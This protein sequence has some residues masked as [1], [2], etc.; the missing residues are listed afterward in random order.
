MKSKTFLGLASA[1]IFG[2]ALFLGLAVVV[3]LYF[4]SLRGAPEEEASLAT[5]NDESTADEF[6]VLYDSANQ[7]ITRVKLNDGS[8]QTFELGL[9]ENVYVWQRALSHDGR[10]L[11]FCTVDQRVEGT[12]SI[13]LIVRDIVASQNIYEQD[14]GNIPGCNPSAFSPDKQR[15]AVGFVYNSPIEGQMNYPDEPDWAL[16]VLDVNSG[17]IVQEIN[18]DSSNAPAF[19]SMTGYWFEEGISPMA[20]V[21]YFGADHIYFLAYPFVG[22]DGPPAV[23]A[24]RWDFASNSLS[25]IEGLGNNGASFLPQTGEIVYPYH[26]PAFPAAQPM[27]PMALANEIVISDSEGTRTIYR[28]T[29]NVIA[30][31]LFV[32]GG[33]QLA[34]F[35]VPHYVPENEAT[36]PT[37]RHILLNR[38]GT[39]E[40][41]NSASQNYA[42]IFATSDGFGILKVEQRD[43]G[44]GNW[45]N[46]HQIF[47]YENEQLNRIWELDAAM[48]PRG[49]VWMELTWASPQNIAPNLEPF[50]AIN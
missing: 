23:P 36:A 16:R 38:D 40:N 28:D 14:F 17:N 24:F 46:F 41:L 9:A 19:G 29:E 32:N 34:V 35:L 26:N 33:R 42:Q 30:S 37:N 49:A 15:L 12:S 50:V 47:V 48:S 11:A 10:L 20:K 1:L 5:T 8:S 31:V 6:V 43:N 7:T 22:R 4:G 45:S 13:R 39:V 21:I 44:G 27:G 3:I 2:A 25:E 18:A